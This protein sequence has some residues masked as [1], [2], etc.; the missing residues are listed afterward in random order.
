M[1]RVLRTCPFRVLALLVAAILVLVSGSSIAGV[2]TW[3][4]TGPEGGVIGTLAFDPSDPQVAYVGTD[5]AGVFRSGDGGLT[6]VA[7]NNGL[8]ST[9][10]ED[11]VVATTG[12]TVTVLTAT[13]A[14]GLFRSLDGGAT[15]T[16]LGA[17]QLSEYTRCI[18]VVPGNPGVLY[19]GAYDGL[20]KTTDGGSTWQR[21]DGGQFTATVTAVAVDPVTP[22]TV[23]ASVSGVGLFMST[24]S[25]ATWDGPAAD[26]DATRI[27]AIVVDPATPTIV[28]AAGGSDGVFKSTD[29]GASWD[30]AST[31]LPSAAVSDLVLAPGS[32]QKLFAA[33]EGSGVARSEDGAESWTTAS[34]GL[35]LL[36]ATSLAVSPASATTLLVGT[37]GRGVARTT[38]AGDSWAEVNSGLSAQDI[39]SLAVE[40]G[41]P[42][43]VYAGAYNSGT[44]K[45]TDGGATWAAA[46]SELEALTVGALVA[47]PGTS[48][49]VFAGTEEGVYR[50][51]DSGAT[52]EKVSTG[53]FFDNVMS[54][55]ADPYQSDLFYAATQGEG[56]FR[57]TD[58]GDTWES[59][60]T[61]L[62]M[63]G[64][65]ADSIEA[66]AVDPSTAGRLYAATYR[67]GV[68][69]TSNGGASWVAANAG[70]TDLRT[71]A[72]GVDSS[73]PT[74]LFVSTLDGLFTSTDGAATWK[75]PM[76]SS[77]FNAF[78][79]T[80]TLPGLVLGAGSG[81]GVLRSSDTGA[82][83]WDFS[84]GLASSYVSALVLAEGAATRFFA[85]T[86]A[87]VFTLDLDAANLCSV[88]LDV[89]VPTTARVGEPISFLASVSSSHC[90][91]ETSYYWY[92]G[93]GKASTFPAA[94]HAYGEAKTYTWQLNVDVGSEH[95]RLSGQITVTEGLPVVTLYIPAVAHAPGDKGTVWRTDLT[96]LNPREDPVSVTLSYVPYGGGTAVQRTVT[97]YAQTA[98]WSDV[99]T[100][101]FNLSDSDSAKGTVWIDSDVHL[102]AVAR[103]YN[104][105]AAGSFGQFIPAIAVG[106]CLAAGEKGVIPGL[107]N[108]SAFRS[109]VG[110]LNPGDTSVGVAL[111]LL[112]SDGAQ[113]GSTRTATIGAGQYWQ[114]DDV[115]AATGAGQRT[116]AYAVV[117]VTT[118]GGRVWAYGSVVDN[119]TGD[120]TTIP[121]L[122]ASSPAGGF[123]TA[124]LAHAPGAV[125]TA[126][127]S[128]F[129]VANPGAASADLALSFRPYDGGSVVTRNHTLAAGATVEW[130]DVL[131]SL[132]GFASDEQHK[133]AVHV[134]TDTPVVLAARTF[135]DTSGGTFGQYLPG[136]SGAA[137]LTSGQVGM[138]PM[139][140][141]STAFRSNVGVL[142]LGDAAVKVSITLFNSSGEERGQPVLLTVGAHAYRQLDDI[143]AV[144]GAAPQYL[145]YAAVHVVTDGGK[146][147]AYG[148]VIDN[149]T[150]D[151][152][153]VPVLVSG[154]NAG[155]LDVSGLYQ[156]T[157]GPAPAFTTTLQQTGSQVTGR[158]L[159]KGIDLSVSGTISGATTQLSGSIGA[160]DTFT[161]EIEQHGDRRSFAGSWEVS[162][163]VPSEGTVTGILEPWP[164]YDVDTLGVPEI[165]QHHGIDLD[166]IAMASKFRSGEGHDFSDDFEDCRSMKHYFAPNSGVDFATVSIRAPFAG[167]VIGGT[168]EWESPSVWKGTAIGIQSLERPEFSMTLF[169]VDLDTDLPIGTV[170][171]A[172]QLLGTS[173]KASGTATD[174]A[175]WVHT[176]TGNKLVSYF[177][178]MTDTAFQPFVARGATSRQQFSITKAERDADPLQCSGQQFADGGSLENW[179]TLN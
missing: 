133:G 37:F 167:I 111:K 1:Q 145:A 10:I 161:M 98:R 140:V 51:T 130:A 9:H 32:P 13:T 64:L 19:V 15:W 28:Y 41:A 27:P 176:P 69:V 141:K 2:N 177:E 33:T 144:A 29:G 18:A 76:M 136:V 108:T 4:S 101:L 134:A 26:L 59:V 146:V 154:V 91:G 99:L 36:E 21:I 110:F 115:F 100:S 175:M 34:T 73:T 121:V 120:P 84:S 150:G 82:S 89:T 172:G 38:N 58:G 40:S 12:A 160:S 63:N 87:G 157:V 126:W 22:A 81:S 35:V 179:V 131:V 153:T 80:P 61:G 116:L 48:G 168:D 139:L 25:G 112:G 60:S 72:L 165:V 178:A 151:P 7:R 159:G 158:L 123:D 135:N 43:I 118:A 125:G 44:F 104:E 62:P 109:N 66:L 14:S 11:V 147:W 54:L 173:E 74:T 68:F 3:T 20:F 47:D 166:K 85:G 31:G 114:Q 65:Y 127:R 97:L 132:F 113:L 162:G 17:G 78:L 138:L 70:L 6:W 156:T 49:T 152:T 171:T 174:Y 46:G 103:T 117:E 96:L 122:I 23:F 56:I 163:D 143:F 86:R 106:D 92:F 129:T 128:T 67:N 75:G 170:V 45:S 77:G 95:T 164:T 83:W 94:H 124:A 30:P 119:Q 102:F 16:R 24:D 5:G 71:R 52:W 142:N 107:K 169:H 50:S 149:T 79:S 39:R 53:Y 155:P 90:A 148:S 8:G 105:A 88:T 93:D 57:T 55:V 42:S 137:C